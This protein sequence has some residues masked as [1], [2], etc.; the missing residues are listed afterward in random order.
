M[1]IL[2]IKKFGDTVVC[3]IEEMNMA[4]VLILTNQQDIHTDLVLREL[5][6]RNVPVIRLHTDEFPKAVH[7]TYQNDDVQVDILSNGRSFRTS[8]VS[9]VWYRR[10]KA[11]IVDANITDASDRI[12]AVAESEHMIENL[13]ALLDKAIW[14]NPLLAGRQ[15]R[16][17]LLQLRVAKQLGLAIPDTLV[18]NDPNAA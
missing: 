1:V 18:T 2:D 16:S 17:K 15:A 6:R 5:L 9:A 12:F 11:P 8:E 14:V 3:S 7:I 4:L 10:P 13:Y